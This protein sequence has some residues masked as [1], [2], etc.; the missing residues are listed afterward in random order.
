MKKVALI[1]ICYGQNFGNRLQNY[2]LQK[3]ITNLGF[4][5]F[6]IEHKPLINKKSNFLVSKIRSWKS[7]TKAEIISDII[8][9]M[10]IRF[11]VIN[12]KYKNNKKIRSES[13]KKFIDNYLNIMS[14]SDYNK[15]KFDYVILGSDQIWNPFGDGLDSFY[16]QNNYNPSQI[17]PYAA[18]FGVETI[19]DEYLMFYRKMLGN[20]LNCSVR[21]ISGK[22]LYET[23]TGKLAKVVLD[24]TLLLE[25]ND[26]EKLTKSEFIKS[27]YIFAYFLGLK[28]FRVLNQI[29]EY[30][31]NKG[32]DFVLCADDNG[33]YGLGPIEFLKYIKNSEMVITDS[34]HGLIFSLVFHKEFKFIQ[35]NVKKCL[36]NMN[37]RI[38]TLF[39]ILSIN[40]DVCNLENLYN[41]AAINFDEID[42]EISLLRQDSIKYLK[43]RLG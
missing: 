5:C 43:D 40:R 9:I 31:K 16:Y 26:W 12:K 13:F 34:Y 22:K 42:K 1:T 4:D 15:I 28:D 35:R 23:I 37:S 36:N 30:A 19:P 21:E 17:I 25:R 8:R 38:E 6:S 29:K 7:L 14:E 27:D 10:K 2:A 24:P 3:I 39:D 32:Y 41:N 20:Y 11:P 18:S 33:F